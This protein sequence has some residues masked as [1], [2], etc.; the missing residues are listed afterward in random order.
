VDLLIDDCAQEGFKGGL[1]VWQA[2]VEGTDF[3]DEFGELWVGG[4]EGGHG[5]GGVVGELAGLAGA[6][7]GHGRMIRLVARKPEG[8]GAMTLRY[9]ICA[10]CKSCSRTRTNVDGIILLVYLSP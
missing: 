5:F 4:G 10:S 3:G 8:M 7:C 1:L 9:S 6:G 2:Y